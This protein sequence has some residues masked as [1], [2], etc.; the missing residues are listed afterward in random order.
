MVF[1]HDDFIKV[2]NSVHILGDKDMTNILIII[3]T[4]GVLV[5]FHEL[6]HLMTAKY[7]G[8]GVKVFSLGFGPKITARTFRGTEYRLSLIPLGGYV[9][10]KDDD[11]DDNDNTITF[12]GAS[13][14]VRSL[15]VL[16]GP[17]ANMILAFVLF[18][19]VF[20]YNGL[21]VLSPVVGDVLPESPA[22]KAQIQAGDTILKIAGVKISD[23]DEVISEVASSQGSPFEMTLLRNEKEIVLNVTPELRTKQTIFGETK[24]VGFVGINPKGPWLTRELNVIEA[25]VKGLSFTWETTVET[26]KAFYMLIVGS[27]PAH[28]IGGPIMISQT[29]SDQ[30]EKGFATLLVLIAVI[31]VNLAIVNMLP[32]PVLDG[33]HILMFA[34]EAARGRPISESIQKSFQRIGLAV[35]LL[36]MLLGTYNDILRL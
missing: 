13:T 26:S 25:A 34:I 29:I 11:T 24:T 2:N 6:G 36:L 23:W 28:A 20:W 16:A 33:G 14:W 31:S 9:S 17:V 12:D 8:I 32:L 1:H 3:I 22:Q 15:V 21:S 18:W 35:I 27:L 10:F 30:A 19:G 4:L 7:Y 5:F